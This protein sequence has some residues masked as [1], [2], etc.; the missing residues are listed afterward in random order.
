VHLKHAQIKSIVAV[1]AMS[2][3]WSFTVMCHTSDK[4]RRRCESCSASSSLI[5][6]SV[7]C[8]Y[9]KHKIQLPHFCICIVMA[10]GVR[11]GGGGS[12]L[13]VHTVWKQLSHETNKASSRLL[14]IQDGLHSSS[15]SPSLVSSPNPA[16]GRASK[17]ST[18]NGKEETETTYTHTGY[19]L[20]PEA[21]CL[22]GLSSFRVWCARLA[23]EEPTGPGT[24][25]DRGGQ[26]PLRGGR[27]ASSFLRLIPWVS[28]RG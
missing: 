15:C 6:V 4:Q 10:L 7:F 26:E 16:H 13:V 2:R 28:R 20:H 21:R 25:C 3:R 18:M 11:R 22:P 23:A 19:S 8:I 27:Q 24:T 17:K 9:F 12:F 14:G 5:S 1:Q